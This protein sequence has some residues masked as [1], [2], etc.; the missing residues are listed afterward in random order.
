MRGVRYRIMDCHLDGFTE[1]P[2]GSRAGKRLKEH[3]HIYVDAEDKGRRKHLES[4]LHEGLHNLAPKTNEAWIHMAAHQLARL[5][6][7]FGYRTVRSKEE[8]D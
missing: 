1:P 8:E 3:R 2:A 4:V 6:W 5:A 7:A